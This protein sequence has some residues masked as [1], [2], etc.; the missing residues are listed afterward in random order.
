MLTGL[1]DQ[2][3]IKLMPKKF[4]SGFAPILIIILLATIV[5]ASIVIIKNIPFNQPKLTSIVQQQS[6][7]STRVNASLSP[8]VSKT[9]TLTTSKKT[10][11]TPTKIPTSTVSNN[12]SNNSG[13]ATST[14][15]SVPANTPT[16]APFPTNPYVRITGPS[17]GES[18]KEGDTVTITWETNMI[19]N[20]NLTLALCSMQ[21]IDSN[22]SGPAIRGYVG[23]NVRSHN[24]TATLGGNVAYNEKQLKISML[25]KDING[26]TETAE[27][28]YFT[29]HK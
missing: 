26:G 14:P 11:L 12:N 20:N 9:P 19:S 7:I 3:N 25:C 29:V 1:V 21:A 13:N 16:A 2:S 15:T 23:V 10:T 22:N 28:N 17:G 8:S 5:G 27:S 18:F 4:Q 24:W 6:T